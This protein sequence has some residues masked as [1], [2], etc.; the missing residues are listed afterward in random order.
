M[1]DTSPEESKITKRSIQL[2][3]FVQILPAIHKYDSEGNTIDKQGEGEEKVPEDWDEETQWGWF[4]PKEDFPEMVLDTVCDIPL[5][6]P[7]MWVVPK[8][9]PEA[10]A[11]E[12]S[13]TQDDVS[14]WTFKKATG[15][16]SVEQVQIK[17]LQLTKNSCIIENGYKVSCTCKWKWTHTSGY[18]DPE[19]CSGDITPGTNQSNSGKLPESGTESTKSCTKTDVTENTTIT[20]TIS[21]KRTAPTVDEKTGM[22]KKPKNSKVST[23]CQVSIF[24]MHR[25]YIGN[26]TKPE[27]G[28]S[29][30]LT[31]EIIKKLGEKNSSSAQQPAQVLTDLES[32]WESGPPEGGSGSSG[33]SGSSSSGSSGSS[34]TPD[35]N[36]FTTAP[37]TGLTYWK[38]IT[39]TKVTSAKNE[40][41]CY[42]YPKELGPITMIYQNKVVEIFN[43]FTQKE[44]SITNDAGKS[45]EYYAYISNHPGAFTNVTLV[46]E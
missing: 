16:E 44:I 11:V 2:E 23:S 40:Y 26:I 13:P 31:E 4:F 39:R 8:S 38:G 25:Y 35:P 34:G 7:E 29:E 42:A 6:T 43:S 33:S 19:E 32:F 36:D 18:N 5:V 24:F 28:A 46:F 9:T 1:A 27:T 14:G 22:L 37:G 21:R 15:N 30:S 17:D 3:K 10:A 20:E 41:F 45:I 12:A